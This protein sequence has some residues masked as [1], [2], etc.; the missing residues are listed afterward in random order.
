MVTDH[1]NLTRPRADLTALGLQIT[2]MP[3]GFCLKTNKQ[4]NKQTQKASSSFWNNGCQIEAD[5]QSSFRLG[6]MPPTTITEM[7][8]QSKRAVLA[9]VKGS[10]F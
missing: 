6:V 1:N 2:E 7:A 4:T 10:G 8:V 3:N 5:S 9:Q